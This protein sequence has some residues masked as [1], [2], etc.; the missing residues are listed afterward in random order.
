MI[1]MCVFVTFIKSW[2]NLIPKYPDSWLEVLPSLQPVILNAQVVDQGRA[3]G[4][5]QEVQDGE[6]LV[7]LEHDQEEA[8]SL[9][10]PVDHVE[11]HGH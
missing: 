4:G 1:N 10:Q 8:D 7:I 3:A 11:L 6:E 5:H 2:S 9:H